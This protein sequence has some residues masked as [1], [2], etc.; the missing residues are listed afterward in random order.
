[1]AKQGLHTSRE[2]SSDNSEY[3]IA[4]YKRSLLLLT[5]GHKRLLSEG[6]NFSNSDEQDITG[7]L[8]RCMNFVIDESEPFN[9][10]VVCEESPENTGG[11]KGKARK[12]VDVVCRLTQR[13]PHLW[14]KFEAK[15]LKNPSHR[16]EL[17]LGNEGLREF[18]SGNYA[19]E[20]DVA[21]MLGYV[22]SDDCG[23]WITQISD[24]L[25]KCKIKLE[26]SDFEDSINC[27]KSVHYRPS[28]GQDILIYHLMLDFSLLR[29]N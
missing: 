6:R 12:K 19:P 17:Y 20:S 22:Q 27:Y 11:R 15:R 24:K 7:E 25:L 23:Y 14:F 18:L 1:M 8:V 9:A 28:I 29:N 21:G 13:S 10:F 26:R 16:V 3:K 4:F 5:C 2:K